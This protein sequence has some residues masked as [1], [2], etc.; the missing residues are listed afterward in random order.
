MWIPKGVTL[1]R[2]RRLFETRRLLKEILI[3]NLTNMLKMPHK[4]IKN[5]F[6]NYV[7]I[8]HILTSVYFVYT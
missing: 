8:S 7:I 6:I 3:L 4:D 1:A 5:M 2:R